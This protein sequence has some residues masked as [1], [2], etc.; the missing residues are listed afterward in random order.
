MPD[1]LFSTPIALPGLTY[2]P[3]YVTDK[4]A[5]LAD[6]ARITAAAPF[7][8]MSTPGGKPMSVFMSRLPLQ[9]DRPADRRPLA[10][11]AG[12][13]VGAGQGGGGGGGV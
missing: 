9:P 10:R 5:V 12:R 13:L 3:G 11:H 8:Q 1:D 7:R 6:I 4:A 2:L